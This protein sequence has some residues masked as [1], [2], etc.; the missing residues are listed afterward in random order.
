MHRLANIVSLVGTKVVVR[1]LEMGPKDQLT[2]QSKVEGKPSNR[3]ALQLCFSWGHSMI[4]GR[5]RVREGRGQVSML[6]IFI[7]TLPVLRLRALLFG[8][9]STRRVPAR[10][11]CRLQD[12]R[13]SV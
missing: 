7:P 1:E 12:R 8:P 3:L 2:V 9:R 5:I 13:E 4:S 11:P 10:R 6:S